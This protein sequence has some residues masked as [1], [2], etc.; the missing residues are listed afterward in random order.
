MLKIKDQS[1]ANRIVVFLKN[2]RPQN[3]FSKIN[4]SRAKN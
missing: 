3:S 2:V 1:F 4:N